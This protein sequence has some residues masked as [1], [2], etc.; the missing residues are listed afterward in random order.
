MGVLSDPQGVVAITIS[1]A[2]VRSVIAFPTPPPVE[3]DV[4]NDDG[5]PDLE[6]EPQS[7]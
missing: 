6:P 1:G 4:E 3:R 7:P 5:E 2:S